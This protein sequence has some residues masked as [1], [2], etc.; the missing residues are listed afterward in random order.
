MMVSCSFRAALTTSLAGLLGKVACSAASLKRLSL[1][2]ERL[3]ADGVF[4]F[5]DFFPAGFTGND[6]G[7]TLSCATLLWKNIL[8]KQRHIFRVPADSPVVL[9]CVVAFQCVDHMNK[10]TRNNTRQFSL[11]NF[12]S[13]DREIFRPV[14]LEKNRTISISKKLENDLIRTSNQTCYFKNMQYFN[15]R[16][17]ILPTPFQYYSSYRLLNVVRY[18]GKIQCLNYLLCDILKHSLYYDL[19]A[20]VIANKY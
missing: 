2:A 19:Q 5:L 16:Y 15:I 1:F 18:G 8:H 3:N 4:F 17:K 9:V 12:L 6:L 14:I 20:I 10:G 7:T 13:N 11:F